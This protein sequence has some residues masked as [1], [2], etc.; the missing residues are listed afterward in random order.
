MAAII[1]ITGLTKKYGSFVAVN[2][3]TLRV[4]KGEFFGFLGPNGA[5]KT[6]TINALVGLAN[7]TQGTITVGGHDVVR[8]FRDARKLI[9]LAPQEFNF[10]RY[11]TAQEVLLYQAGYF[12][13]SK[14]NAL[15][16]ALHLL[17][18]FGLLKK[19]SSNVMKLSGG[20]KRR[21]LLARAL[22]HQPQILILDEP[23]A[24]V[25]VELRME[26]WK[27]LED[28]NKKG[29][30]I[31]LTTHYLEEA[32]K[33]CRRIAIIHNGTLVACGDKSKLL[34]NKKLHDLYLSLTKKN[35]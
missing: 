1:S 25:D 23:T 19:K 21:L 30:T 15:P 9:G 10:D 14:K 34:R 28:E 3:L 12:G 2:N 20:Q 31:F 4:S 27:F 22:I 16:R 6:T 11:L 13:I 32:E 33:L 18:Q 17:E 5:G 8:E 29:L 7:I 26:L 24:G 35:D